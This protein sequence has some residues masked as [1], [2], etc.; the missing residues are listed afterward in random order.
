MNRQT[1]YSKRT[2]RATT[3]CRAGGCAMSA[4]DLDLP[5]DIEWVDIWNTVGLRG[6]ASEG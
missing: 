1:S 4:A 2:A 6:T 3:P 5:V